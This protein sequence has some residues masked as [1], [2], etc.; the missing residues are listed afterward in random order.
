MG[1]KLKIGK[2]LSARVAGN[3]YGEP[4]CIEPNDGRD[5]GFSVSVYAINGQIVGVVVVEEGVIVGEYGLVPGKDSD[6]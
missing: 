6:E 3:S 4:V 1:T 5:E 2:R